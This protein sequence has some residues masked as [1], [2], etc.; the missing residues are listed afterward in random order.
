MG[1]DRPPAARATFVNEIAVRVFD[2]TAASILLLLLL[3][4][5]VLISIGIVLD[6]RGP[7][8][9]GCNRVGR[10][11]RT[12]RML[13]FR[14]MKEGA[15]GPPLTTGADERFTRFGRLLAKSKLDEVP[16]LWNV[17]SGDMSLVGPRPED[18]SFVGL[19]PADYEEILQVPPGIT[20][21]SQ[22]AF[23]KESQLL[24]AEDIHGYYVERLLPQKI[25]L[26]RLYA[27]R[28]SLLLN[29]QILLWTTVVV[30]LLAD[31]AVNR[32]SGRLTFRRRP[33]QPERRVEPAELAP[34]T[35]SR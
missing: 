9:Y 12:F 7:V 26:D 18:R 32:Q 19:L 22:L 3:P 25:A 13:K 33:P 11:G 35:R 29:L 8:L 28:R 34:E 14:K 10:Y 27:R 15:G 6:S 1:S 2:A 20:G 17:V 5:I 21:L 30:S 4:L 16:Q 31:V 23:A 24:A